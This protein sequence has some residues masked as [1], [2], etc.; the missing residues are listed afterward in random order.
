MV[1]LAENPLRVGL[2]QERVPD[3]CIL[4]QFG[5]S[6][7]LA[8]RKLIPAYYRLFVQRRLPPEFTLVGV[9]RRDW[10]HEIYRDK[11]RAALEEF[12]PKIWGQKP[13]GKT[14]PAACSTVALILAM[15]RATC[16]SSNSSANWM[17]SGAPAATGCFIWRWRRTSTPRPSNSWGQPGCWLTRPKRG[18]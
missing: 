15:P 17:R 10:S 18:W 1:T 3:P 13:S 11:M 16:V 6:G 12:A 7:D 4:V 5:A 14:L 9:A 8:A 2:N